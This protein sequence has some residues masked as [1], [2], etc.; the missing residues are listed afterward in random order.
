ML[1]Y[2]TYWKKN[3]WWWGRFVVWKSAVKIWNV[4]G[5]LEFRANTVI[6]NMLS[7]EKMKEKEEFFEVT[8]IFKSFPTKV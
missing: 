4:K 1:P 5:R 3:Y 7:N 8:C 6:V 2:Y